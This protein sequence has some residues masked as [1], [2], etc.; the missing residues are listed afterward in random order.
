VS[1]LGNSLPPAIIATLVVYCLKEINFFSGNH[2]FPEL[3]AVSVVA[4]LHI[5]KKNTLISIGF[6]TIIYM[7]LIQVVFV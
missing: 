4:L 5:W 2:G 1:F 7:I 3:I 6:G